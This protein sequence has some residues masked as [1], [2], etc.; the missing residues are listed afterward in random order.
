MKKLIT[1]GVMLLFLGMTI[2][3]ST[4]FNLEKQS[5]IATLGGNTLYVGGSGPNNYTKIQDAVDNASDGDTVFV[6]NGTYYE[7]IQIYSSIDLIGEDTNTTIIDGYASRV[8]VYADG[9]KISGFSITNGNGIG[10]ASNNT[11][12]S[13]NYF[14]GDKDKNAIEIGRKRNPKNNNTVVN[15][16]I[17]TQCIDVIGSFNIFSY[18][19]VINPHIGVW[20]RTDGLYFPD[21]NNTIAFNTIVYNEEYNETGYTGIMVYGNSNSSIYGNF[22]SILAPNGLFALRTAGLWLNV[23]YDMNVYQNT[24][25]NF[26]YGIWGAGVYNATIYENN[27]MNCTYGIIFEEEPEPPMSRTFAID[28]K[29]NYVR[30]NNFFRVLF[31]A[32]NLFRSPKLFRISN[33]EENYWNRPRTL[34]KAIIGFIK[35]S[36][37]LQAWGIP[38]RLQFDWHP[39]SEPYDIGV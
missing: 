20:F 30:R 13:D 4:G 39:A 31:P 16:T 6:Y 37:I 35:I 8:Y 7:Y 33:W 24:I 21:Y 11:Y 15:N 25:S 36:P 23:C 27:I 12:I 19:T 32:R 38:A 26:D 14:S 22:I 9:V 29:P 5:T 34:P 3:S 2:S 18:N 17:T 10:V 28:D 1:L